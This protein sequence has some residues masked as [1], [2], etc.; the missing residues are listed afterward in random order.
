MVN[1]KLI[2]T[3]LLCL[4]L[5]NAFA[6]GK[7]AILVIADGTGPA[8]MG[9]LMQYARQSSSPLYKGDASN[10]EKLFN[11]SQLGIILN[12]P[13]DTIATDSAASGTQLATGTTTHP[14][15]IGMDAQ[16][17]AVESMLE[18][19]Q[20][21]NKSVGVVTDVF[22]IDATPSA[23]YAHQPSR[24]MYKN[25]ALDMLKTKPDVVLG[26]GMDYFISENFKTKYANIAK[27]LPYAKDLNPRLQDDEVFESIL[28]SG[29]ALIFDKKGLNS[30]K[31]D[32]ILGLFA[33]NQIPFAINP[34]PYAPT[35][36]EMAQKAVETLSK[37]ENGFFLMVE[38][39][40]ID[41]VVHDNDQGAALAELLE[42]DETLK[43]L[44]NWAKENGNTL[45]MVT[46]DHDTGGFGINYHRPK[47]EELEAKKAINY[48]LYEKDDYATFTNWDII[49]QQKKMLRDLKDEYEALSEKQK[50][51]KTMQKF[52]KDNMGYDFSLEYLEEEDDIED[53]LKEAGKRLG[54]VWSTDH[55]TASPLFI[56]FYGNNKPLPA[57]VLHSSKLKGIVDNYLYE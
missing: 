57:T 9:M 31:S 27:K 33:A 12:T 5:S 53:V 35:L 25:I 10:M 46:A 13:I 22:V 45:L 16:H 41:W 14:G 48:K 37:N 26:G 30:V 15:V 43:Y 39:G 17:K 50:N 34:A 51:P 32:K 38:A 18:T 3:A 28:K 49:A 7:N 54:I 29:Y 47:G 55:H 8:V 2:V 11:D 40:A 1:K 20:K 44:H 36:K 19:A 42:L 52:I 21:H 24:K 4:C 56:S 23:F 6:A